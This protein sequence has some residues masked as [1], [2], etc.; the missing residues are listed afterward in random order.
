MGIPY[1]TTLIYQYLFS[2]NGPTR[3]VNLTNENVIIDGYSLF[4]FIYYMIKKE[5]N[6]KPIN[7][8]ITTKK[9]SYEG[10]SKRFEE[11]L[12]EFKTKCAK[13]M[14]VFDGISQSNKY[15]RRDPK[16]DSTVQF[17]NGRSRLPRLLHDEL[18]HI[19]HQ[20]NI[21]VHVTPDEADPIIVQMAQKH[22][23]FIVARDSDYFLYNTTKGYVPLDKMELKTLQGTYY[24]MNDVFKDILQEGIALW[25]TTI[26][27]DVIHLDVLQ[28][29]HHFRLF[30]SNIEISF[31]ILERISS[32]ESI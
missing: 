25:A 8:Q 26:T 11:I 17:N 21:N 10:L 1:F 14:V 4:Y 29:I 18:I 12:K 28:V 22:N 13:L 19:L 15:R 3:Q 24:R 6:N 16:R 7:E 5:D 9:Y 32:G 30:K 27:Y 31:R 2:N 20:L 23:A